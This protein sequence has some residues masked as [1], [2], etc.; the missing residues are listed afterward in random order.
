MVMEGVEKREGW[1][2]EEVKARRK[3]GVG[4]VRRNGEVR[5]L[6]HHCIKVE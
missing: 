1:N 2:T 6:C 4:M 5:G 3:E